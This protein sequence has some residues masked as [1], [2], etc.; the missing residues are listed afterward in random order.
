MIRSD[1]SNDDTFFARDGVRDRIR[2]S[3]GFD[4][5]HADAFDIDRALSDIERLF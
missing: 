5:A 3:A 4:R 2:G 1:R